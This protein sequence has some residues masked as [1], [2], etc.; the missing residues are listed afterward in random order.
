ML[1]TCANSITYICY[2]IIVQITINVFYLLFLKK[3][4]LVCVFFCVT[5]QHIKGL[6]PFLFLPI[7]TKI[8]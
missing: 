1:L 2:S 7:E 4:L 8:V 6:T 5:L 3:E